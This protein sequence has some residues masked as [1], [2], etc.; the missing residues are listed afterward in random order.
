MSIQSHV[1]FHPAILSDAGPG[2]AHR[3]RH[4]FSRPVFLRTKLAQAPAARACRFDRAM[5]GRQRKRQPCA[6]APRQQLTGRRQSGRAGAEASARTGPRKPKR[7]ARLPYGRKSNTRPR[8][9][10]RLLKNSARRANLRLHRREVTHR[11][12]DRG[13]G[14]LSETSLARPG[15]VSTACQ[16]LFRAIEVALPGACGNRQRMAALP[17]VKNLIIAARRTVA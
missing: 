10:E 4:G 15:R 9:L 3:P 12:G 6:I 2:R 7:G 13:G 11:P 5:T 16:A 8:W 1:E 14:L 17:G